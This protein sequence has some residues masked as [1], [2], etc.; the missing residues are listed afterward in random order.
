MEET[1]VHGAMSDTK[2]QDTGADAFVMPV[3]L[4]SA[5]EIQ[6]VTSQW[7]CLVG[8]GDAR[9]VT[10][11]TCPGGTQLPSTFVHVTCPG[12]T[13]IFGNRTGYI[14]HTSIKHKCI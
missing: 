11:V 12:F 14:H 9:T 1:T 3:F 7:S 4:F 5:S 8:D 2:N 13:N 10:Q 6:I